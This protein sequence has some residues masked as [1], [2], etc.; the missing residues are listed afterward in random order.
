MSYLRHEYQ[1]HTEKTAEDHRQRN[2]YKASVLLGCYDHGNGGGYQTQNDHIVNAHANV[3]R[4]VD[5]L[6]FYRTRFVCQKEAKHQ[7]ESFEAV[8]QTYEKRPR[9]AN[10]SGAKNAELVNN[11]L[12]QTVLLTLSQCSSCGRIL[13]SSFSDS[14]SSSANDSSLRCSGSN[15]CHD[16]SMIRS[17]ASKPVTI[18]YS[19]HGSTFFCL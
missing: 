9:V 6:H 16:I 8:D 1:Q 14:G 17:M 4:V 7:N 3:A 5:L 15:T 18:V 12:S 13:M 19:F 10:G 2:E 11:S